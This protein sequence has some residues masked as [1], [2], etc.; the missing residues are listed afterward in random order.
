MSLFEPRHEHHLA[1][2]KRLRR[3][4][5][6]IVTAIPL[7][8]LPYPLLRAVFR[9]PGWVDRAFLALL[10]LTCFAAIVG[11]ELRK[12]RVFLK[13]LRERENQQDR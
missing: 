2:F 5:R 1:E 3:I 9:P 11:L 12:A 4:Q 7:A 13:D 8:G 10:L 6:W